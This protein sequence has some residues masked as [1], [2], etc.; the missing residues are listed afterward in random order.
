MAFE[1][2]FLFFFIFLFGLCW[3]SFLNVLAYRL[4]FDKPFFTARSYCPHC[5]KNIAWYDNIPVISWLLLGGKCRNCKQS[6]TALY[7]FF[8]LITAIVFVLVAVKF[9]PRF[10]PMYYLMLV[11]APA[12]DLSL[13]VGGMPNHLILHAGGL[14]LSAGLFLSA[15]IAATHTDVRAMVIPQLFSIWL[16]PVGIMLSVF[17]FTGITYKESILGAVIG[18]GTLWVVA[19]AFKF[20]A[21]KEGLGVGDMELLCMIGAF[22]GPVGVWFTLMIGSI[23]GM[24]LGGGYLLISGNDRMT[25][26]PFGPFFSLGA[27]IYFFC[28]QHITSF[29]MR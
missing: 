26:I 5:R 23:T 21:K 14:L 17:N 9:F 8:E 4:A 15:L 7:L 13:F 20:F 29:L 18:Y 12:L 27:A 25:R 10:F 11:D 24:I 19:A 1:F 28:G 22:L 3:G 2:V 16:A 6:I